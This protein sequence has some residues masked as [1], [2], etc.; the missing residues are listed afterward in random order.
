MSAPWQPVRR[1]VSVTVSHPLDV[2]VLLVGI[3]RWGGH[4]NIYIHR[5]D[6]RPFNLLIESMIRL[7]YALRLLARG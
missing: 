5:P 3:P 6:E 1:S 2:A 4:K 7:G